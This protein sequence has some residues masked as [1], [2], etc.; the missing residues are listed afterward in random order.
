MLLGARHAV[1]ASCY[2][3]RT[4]GRRTFWVYLLINVAA[5]VL[6]ELGEGFLGQSR[7]RGEALVMRWHVEDEWRR[8]N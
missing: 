6:V 8:E 4:Q 5:V 3:G 7:E 2:N 1:Q